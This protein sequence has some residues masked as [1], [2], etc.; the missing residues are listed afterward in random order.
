MSIEAVA[1]YLRAIREGRGLTQ[2]ELAEA[3]DV[4]KRTIERFERNE[5]DI[6]GEYL[7]RIITVLRAVPEDVQYLWTHPSATVSEARELAATVLSRPTVRAPLNA[8]SPAP[9]SVGSR[10]YIR[11]LR[12]G[13]SVTRKMLADAIGISLATFADW[14]R[15]QTIGLP[16]EVLIRAT[17]YL[18]GAY[19]DL[20]QIADERD[21]SDVVALRLAEQRLA[22]VGSPARASRRPASTSDALLQRRLTAVEGV[23]HYAL[24][25]LKRLMPDEADEIERTSALWF[26]GA[27][28]DEGER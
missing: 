25:L 12:E 8:H 1:T 24:S 21:G 23:A 9:E 7:A 2:Q 22:E 28:R 19:E 11:V 20:V 10:T 5:G 18:G 13:H 26:K 27:A 4:S 6:T 17:E 3:A 14:E 16:A 15:G